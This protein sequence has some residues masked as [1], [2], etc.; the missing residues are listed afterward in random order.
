[1]LPVCGFRQFLGEKSLRPFWHWA[2]GGQGTS[3][4]WLHVCDRKCYVE[5]TCEFELKR[6]RRCVHELMRVKTHLGVWYLLLLSVHRPHYLE[7]QDTARPLERGSTDRQKCPVA[8]TSA[9]YSQR[10]EAKQILHHWCNGVCPVNF[11]CAQNTSR[12]RLRSY[13]KGFSTVSTQSGEVIEDAKSLSGG[14]TFG[15]TRCA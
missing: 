10:A 15:L 13:Q 14:I 6:F 2:R 8:W 9:G 4:Y 12:W 1:M 3:W 5:G 7:N 11:N